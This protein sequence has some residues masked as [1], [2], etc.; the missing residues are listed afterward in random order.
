M[1]IRLHAH[2]PLLNEAFCFGVATASFQIEGGIEHREPCNWDVFCQQP[3]AIADQSDGAVA[4]DHFHRWKEDFALIKSLGVDAYRMSISWPRVMDANGQLKQEGVNY[5][6]EQLDWLNANNIKPF[7]TLYHWDLPQHIEENGGWLNRETAYLYEQYVDAITQA[8]GDRVYSYATFNEPFCS[9]YLGYELGIHAPGITGTKN[10]RTAGHHLLLAHGLGMAVLRKNAP[11]ALC[12]IVLN[13]TP[14]YPASDSAEDIAAAK[15]A[16]QILNQWLFQPVLAGS[17]PEAVLTEPEGA[18]PPVEEGD[19]ALIS[20]PID[21]LGINYYTREVYQSA[22][23]ELYQAVPEKTLPLTDM[24]WE[25]FPQ[26]LTDVLVD[27]HQRYTL[28]PLYITENGAAMPDTLQNG[29]VM[30]TDRA[31]Y[32][33]THLQAVENAMQQGVDIRGYFAWSLLDN[34]EWAEGYVKRFGIVYV[35]YQ[36]QQRTLK[37]SGRCYQALLTERRQSERQEQRA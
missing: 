14:T 31:E 6:I 36:T 20:T 11:N 4:C 29:E 32:I 3:G 18:A 33:Q 30:D 5:Y 2:S 37:Y 9:A 24:G 21:F 13:I 26:G 22:E 17:Y 34:F 7:I 25:V 8:F 35:D 16:D 27:L 23:G 1:S 10:G 19:L 28:P 12:G 15:M